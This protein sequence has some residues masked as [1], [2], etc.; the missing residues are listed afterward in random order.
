MTD[1]WQPISEWLH[2]G[3]QHLRGD[4]VHLGVFGKHPSQ[5]GHLGLG[6][7]GPL[8]IL[9]HTVYREG[10][11][12]AVTSGVWKDLPDAQRLPAFS[13]LIVG[14]AAQE[15]V[16][17]RLWDSRDAVGRTEFPM[18]AG[19]CCS[20]A[21][22]RAVLD[23]VIPLLGRL[24][25]CACESATIE[26]VQAVV[27]VERERLRA[28]WRGVRTD[29]LASAESGKGD[30]PEDWA[31]VGLESE[32]LLRVL[33]QVEGAVP[34][35]ARSGAAERAG[36]VAPAS[37]HVRVPLSGAPVEEGLLK[38]AAFFEH[39]VDPRMPLLMMAP[40]EGGW[41][42][43]VI[44]RPEPRHFHLLKLTLVKEPLTS[45]TPYP[46]AGNP[47][48][49]TRV[50]RLLKAVRPQAVPAPSVDT[51]PRPMPEP[52]PKEALPPAAAAPVAEPAPPPPAPAVARPEAGVSSPAAPE[53]TP[54][55][56]GAG[57]HR[58]SPRMILLAVVALVGAALMLK[59]FLGGGGDSPSPPEGWNDLVKQHNAWVSPLRKQAAD[60]T[61]RDV[62]SRDPYPAT[63]ILGALETLPA[64]PSLAGDPAATAEAPTEGGW[65]SLRADSRSG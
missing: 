30:S 61:R 43:V 41:L 31:A 50:Q 44:G 65:E 32:G 35:L 12:Q 52:T 3:W 13:H 16:V 57:Q 2:S 36:V 10:I 14:C 17:G 40:L 34:E 60:P 1:P 38:W 59:G 5:S 62:R 21:P 11:G 42:D 18:G 24:E 19:A 54:K 28:W 48:F 9:E 33:S 56:H 45:D 39:L 37:H 25:R 29:A 47:E 53:P 23:R 46:Y 4:R 58:K 22:L 7:D 51:R 55:A 64:R 20:G 6:M 15:V 49:V 63:H 8:S 26:E 27:A